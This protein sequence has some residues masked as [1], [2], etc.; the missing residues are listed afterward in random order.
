MP[1]GRGT[2]DVSVRRY[3]ES[4]EPFV[5]HRSCRRFAKVSERAQERCSPLA[6]YRPAMCWAMPVRDFVMSIRTSRS[7]VTDMPVPGVVRAS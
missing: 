7:P 5:D 4:A 1:R 2:V 6:V 3:G